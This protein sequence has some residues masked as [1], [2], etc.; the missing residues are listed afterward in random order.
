MS[1]NTPTLQAVPRTDSRMGMTVIVCYAT[2]P[3]VPVRER[4]GEARN[5]PQKGGRSWDFMGSTRSKAKK[6]S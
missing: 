1:T 2:S 3:P 6:L 4:G 5:A